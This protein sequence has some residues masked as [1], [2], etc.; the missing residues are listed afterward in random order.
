M[1]SPTGSLKRGSPA[2]S[3]T[4][5]RLLMENTDLAA[6]GLLL[7]LPSQAVSRG[8]VVRSMLP[9][10][11]LR[12]PRSCPLMSMGYQIPKRTWRI[13]HHNSLHHI[14]TDNIR[15]SW[16]LSQH[17]TNNLLYFP[18]TFVFYASK[19]PLTA[20]EISH[21]VH[22]TPRSLNHPLTGKTKHE[23]RVAEPVR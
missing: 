12:L 11:D 21:R 10:W 16:E 8:R 9:H 3:V 20:K 6:R 14:T 15:S 7:P 22:F 1:L 18:T 4:S 23:L 13:T 19:C 5:T 2:S 17:R